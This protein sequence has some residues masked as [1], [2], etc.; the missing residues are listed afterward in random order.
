MTAPDVAAL[1]AARAA[2]TTGEWAVYWGTHIA[3]GVVVTSPG[4]VQVDYGICEMEDEDDRACSDNEQ[5]PASP[6]ADAALIV[7]AVNALP[8]LLAA[9]RER[10]ALRAGIVRL[11]MEDDAAR[12]DY[13]FRARNRDRL[14]ALLADVDGGQQ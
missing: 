14:R 9:V 1:E 6:S 5:N 3:S 7:A 10:D 13:G 2:A 11:A 4:G 8:G 12:D